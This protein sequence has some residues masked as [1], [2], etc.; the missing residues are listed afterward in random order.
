[1]ITIFKRLYQSRF[2]RF[3]LIGV[4]N[5]IIHLVIYN[6][7]LNEIDKVVLSQIIAFIIASLFSYWAN[8]LFTY[9]EKMR[10]KTFYLSMLTFIIKLLLNAGLAKAFEMLFIWLKFISLKKIIPLFI[11]AILLP[12]QFLVFNKIFEKSGEY[13]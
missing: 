4:V 9:R 12:L 7:L 6:L 2:I 3:C 10:R 1:M 13:K 11:T 5:T 8:T